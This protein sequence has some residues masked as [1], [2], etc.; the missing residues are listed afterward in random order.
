LGLSA[1]ASLPPFGDLVH[2][3]SAALADPGAN[4][5]LDGLDCRGVS[6]DVF[7]FLK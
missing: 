1:S 6:H 3:V 2:S 7:D 5:T 4:N